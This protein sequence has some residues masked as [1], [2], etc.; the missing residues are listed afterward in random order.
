MK[1]ACLLQFH[2]I[3]ILLCIYITMLLVC[4]FQRIRHY[5]FI[6]VYENCMSITISFYTNI[7]MFIILYITM[8]LAHTIY[9]YIYIDEMD[10]YIKFRI[11][12]HITVI[13]TW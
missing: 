9:I 10:L 2:F 13:P 6:T 7:I 4:H 8:L 5:F 1:I 11:S 3:L 12:N